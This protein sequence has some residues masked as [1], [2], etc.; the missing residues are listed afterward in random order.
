MGIGAF[1]KGAVKG[2]KGAVKKILPKKDD[3]KGS[4][5]DAKAP[6]MNSAFVFIKPHANTRAVQDL[7]VAKLTSK[8]V[9]ILAEGDIA[10]AIRAYAAALDRHPDHPETHQ[11]LAVALLLGGDIDGARKGF[12]V[13]IALLDDQGRSEEAQALYKQVQG[14]VKLDEVGA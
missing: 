3:S 14:M 13:A 7:V 6:L 4:A 9:K 10:A 1:L 11:N 5:A 12:R 8:R 2:V